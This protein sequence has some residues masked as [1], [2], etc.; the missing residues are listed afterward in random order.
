[1]QPNSSYGNYKQFRAKNA[2]NP[3]T[4][5]R[6]DIQELNQISKTLESLTFKKKAIRE[7]IKPTK[8]PSYQIIE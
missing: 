4:M 8:K 5:K 2:N 3:K 1:M 6:P 7:S